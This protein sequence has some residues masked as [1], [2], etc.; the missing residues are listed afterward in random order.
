VRKVTEIDDVTAPIEVSSVSGDELL[1]RAGWGGAELIKLTLSGFEPF[2]LRGLI[3]TLGGSQA[4]SLLI[5]ECSAHALTWYGH[6]PEDLREQ[7]AGL[8]YAA[9]IVDRLAPDRV[10]PT[11][12][13]DIQT[14]CVSTLLAARD[15]ETLLDLGY[16]VERYSTPEL[17]GR[18]LSACVSEGASDRWHAVREIERGP[19]WLREDRVIAAVERLHRDPVGMVRDA[20][21][22]A[23][24][25]RVGADDGEAAVDRDET[26]T[27]EVPGAGR[28]TFL[29]PAGPVDPVVRELAVREDYPPFAPNHLLLA[30]LRPG[31]T[32][33]D[34]G[35]HVGT[36][37]LPA[38]ALGARVVAVDAHPQHARLLTE[39]AALNGFSDRLT[40]VHGA[41][42]EQPGEV[43]LVCA[44]GWSFVE[45][46]AGAAEQLEAAIRVRVRALPTRDVLA[47]AGVSCVDFIK[48]DLEGSEQRALTGMMELLEGP[49]APPVLYE[50]NP[51]RLKELGSSERS[52]GEA[53]TQLG[54]R[55][56]KLEQSEHER[57]L[58]P[59]TPDAFLPDPSD[60]VLAAKR[61][62]DLE[63]WRV[64]VALSRHDQVDRAL[65]VARSPFR[66]HRWSLAARLI[67]APPWLLRDPLIREALRALRHDV[68]PLV[69]EAAAWSAHLS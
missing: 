25:A 33:L 62:P 10:V 7:L 53:F 42:A 66:Q 51:G 67:E 28:V 21:W 41:V 23:N 12:P 52:L 24:E 20:A 37:S 35:S 22:W 39:A 65:Q 44:F 55:L 17:T 4:P 38:A 16:H 56:Y 54:Y 46:P 68:H 50:V 19:A 1:A 34:L 63:G 3:G 59:I 6:T 43:D 30:M 36:F 48:M 14:D 49:D 69:R 13:A 45:P 5:L 32:F 2:A 18:L 47:E 11:G 15:P 61:E 64:A 26:T 58:V 60:D 29:L 31:M 27:M 40:V 9:F 8:G 57:L